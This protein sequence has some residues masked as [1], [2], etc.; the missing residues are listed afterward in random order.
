MFKTLTQKSVGAE[1]HSFYG[2]NFSI[3]Y[4]EKV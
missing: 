4:N 1:K 2:I 3:L